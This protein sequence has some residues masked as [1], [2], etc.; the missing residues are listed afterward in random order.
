VNRRKFIS[1][2]GG[3]AA[4]W[5][6][7]ARAQQPAMPV[8]GFMSGRSP[9]DSVHLVA[10]FRQGLREGG[11]VERQNVAIEYRWA[12]G[13]YGQL[14]A[15]AAE[16]VKLRVNVLAGVGGDPSARAAKAATSTIPVVFGMGGDPIK[17]GLVESLNRPGGNA[18]GFTILTNEMEPKRLGLLHELVP[19]I[20]LF[21]AILNPNFPP[22]AGQLNDLEEAARK[23]GQRV[24][25]A[26]ASNDS[27]LDAALAALLRERVGALLVA[28][29]PY[30]DTR[31]DRII[32]FAAQNRLPAM[33]QFREYAVAGG[34]IS[35]G[36][37]IT[38]AYRQ[39]GIYAARILN[40]AKPADLPVVQPTKFE[41]V[42]NLKTAKALGFE[43]PP[44]ISARADEV[45]E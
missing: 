35:Y 26:R 3:A 12:R 1:L 44:A 6:F 9:E 10:A 33:Y 41:F 23:I 21:G 31:R 2:L 36:P 28:A 40:G 4:A 15:L 38:D 45:I 39:G 11:F 24:V 27:E 13:D 5:P 29:D 42:I 8:V 30:F 16:L 20:P 43:I 7:A 17:A 22:A 18:T 19:G 14:P 34:L 25:V 37:S 32:A